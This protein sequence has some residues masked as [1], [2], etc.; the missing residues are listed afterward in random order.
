MGRKIYNGTAGSGSG[1]G[2][3]SASGTT[4][5]PITANTNL[6]FNADGTGQT[7]VTSLLNNSNNTASSSLATGALI[8]S[9]GAGIEKNI[10]MA[11]AVNVVG[12]VDSPVGISPATASSGTFTSVTASGLST[13]E[14][15]LDVSAAKTG[16]TG[17]VVHDFTESNIWYHSSISANFT[18]NLTN[19]PTTNDRTITISL[20]LD[21][22]GTPRYANAFQIDGV[23]QTLRY[24]GFNTSFTPTANRKEIQTFQ[25]T[26]VSSAWTVRVFYSSYGERLGS[27]PL[28]AA[29][30]ATA[31][32]TANPSATSGLYWL[33]PSAWTYPALCYCEMTLH[34]GGWV[35]I[36]QRLCVNDQGLYGSYLTSQ[37]GFPNH[38]VQN[39]YGTRDL[40][41][42]ALTPQNMWDGL[43]GSGAATGKFFAREIQIVTGNVGGTY[44]ESQR[45]VSSSDGP[46]WTWATFSRLFA[47]NFSNG[48]F[49]SG[50]TIHYNDGANSVASKIGTTWSAPSL[51]TINNGNVDQDLWFCNG[52]DGGD[53]NWS[54]ALMK[55]GTPYPRTADATNGGNRHNNISRW[56][57][58]GIKA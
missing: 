8:V 51:A 50:V 46:I 14:S 4:I 21:Q 16:A 29:T 54:F 19:V 9:G 33:K 27:S 22:G 48:Q 15:I 32:K 44:S 7:I 38:T 5:T 12:G 55:G 37:L 3:L 17:T 11:G 45:Y 1:A 18:V 36:M 28:N 56:A 52:E 10:I 42:N 23:A 57:I 53:S 34:G 31:I 43:I 25:L 6:T 13:F 35:Y 47:G 30:S 24:P 39:F 40:M 58:I 20:I 49:Q 26:R 2:T 41:N